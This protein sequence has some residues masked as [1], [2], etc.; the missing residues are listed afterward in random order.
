MGHFSKQ[1]DLV[2]LSTE[3]YNKAIVIF[4]KRHSL[5]DQIEKWHCLYSCNKLDHPV[6]MSPEN[7]PGGF[8]K[9]LYHLTNA[10]YSAANGNMDKAIEYVNES[11]SSFRDFQSDIYLTRACILKLLIFISSQQSDNVTDTLR[12]LSSEE[13]ARLKNEENLYNFISTFDDTYIKDYF[14]NGYSAKAKAMMAIKRKYRPSANMAVRY[15]STVVVKDKD[16][17]VLKKKQIDYSQY[18]MIPDHYL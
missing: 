10:R 1:F 11:I 15:Y 7:K 12:K 5:A 6:V 13:L 4:E 14:N 16:N 17:Y 2:S 9:G 8:L 18:I 3:F